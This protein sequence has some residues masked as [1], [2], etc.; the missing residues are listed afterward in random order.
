MTDKPLP[1]TD[2]LIDEEHARR[3]K[4][5]DDCDHK[6]YLG[7]PHFSVILPCMTDGIALLVARIKT[8]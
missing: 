5:Y 8:P 6:G 1:S 4:K 7:I 2:D 3:M